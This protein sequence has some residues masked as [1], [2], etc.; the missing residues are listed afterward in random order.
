MISANDVIEKFK[1]RNP[2]EIIIKSGFNLSYDDLKDIQGYTAKID[3]KT[4]IRIG[5]EVNWYVRRF[6]AA[7]LLYHA[8][9]TEEKIVIQKQRENHY[10]SKHE[11]D[12]NNFAYELLV[13]NKD[14]EQ[15]KDYKTF[16]KTKGMSDNEIE[17]ITSGIRANLTDEKYSE[18]YLKQNSKLYNVDEQVKYL[19]LLKKFL[20]I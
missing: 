13:P 3:G 20:S 1:T 11:I 9:N 8:I 16:M 15:Y 4:F 2:F 17:E 6:V 18:L 19:N 14:M 5:N 10:Y 7:N 12:G